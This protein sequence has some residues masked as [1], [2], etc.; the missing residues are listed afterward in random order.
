MKLFANLRVSQKLLL[1]FGVLLAVIAA[2]F[3]TVY[4]QVDKIE[5]S[6]QA[7]ARTQTVADHVAKLQEA[8]EDQLN[9]I[10]GLLISGD[11]TNVSAY[12]QASARF[13]TGLAPT[14]RL[15]DADPAMRTQVEQMAEIVGNW[16]ATAANVQIERTLHPMQVNEARAIEA[17][18]AGEAY[19]SALGAAANGIRG[20]IEAQRQQLSASMEN[21][22][23]TAIVTVVVG[24]IVSILIA[25]A[26]VLVLIQAIASPI[27]Q[28]T[29]TMRTLAGGETAVEVPFADRKDEI[30]AM[31][32]AVAVFKINALERVRLE[33]EQAVE[34]EVKERRAAQVQALAS[35]FGLAAEGA[36]AAVTGAAT[37]LEGT[38]RSMTSIAEETTRQS[39]ASAASAQ[40]TSGNVQTVAA[41]AEEMAS[42]LGEI[43]RQVSR[44]S[45][46]VQNAVREADQTNT[47]VGAL[48]DAAQR[49]N[50]VVRLIS[51]IAAQTNLLALNA[52]IEAA[53]AGEAGKGFAVVASEVKS[54]ANQTSKATDE[55]A[56]QIAA[57]QSATG[58]VVG[59]IGGIGRTISSIDEITTTISA[60]VEEQNAATGE[61]SF[62]VQQ[63]AAGTMEV[64]RTIEG[65]RE[66]ADETGNAANQVLE[67]ADSMARE[68]NTLRDEIEK[69]L[70]GLRAA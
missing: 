22:V 56:A 42:S 24:A 31:A 62:S 58:S 21:A 60:A 26:S 51:D 14:L 15:L 52:T 67:A 30:G 68:A 25:V 64:S 28:I 6:R 45:E 65:V 63:A 40:Q 54:L 20:D 39:A 9:R 4:L 48:N 57:M 8:A 43:A 44:A 46:V 32:G 17:V 5:G 35:A 66:A 69:F 37:E 2:T 1:A 70:S 7:A 10:R 50:E 3:V 23:R 36:L 55:I 27:R 59:A 11:R 18:G 33:A 16:Q 12:E 47:Q 53:R 19:L 29:T 61:I 34:R 49:I 41:A 38:A 13:E